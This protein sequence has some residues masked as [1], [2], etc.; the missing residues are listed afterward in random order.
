MGLSKD[1]PSITEFLNVDLDIHAPFDLQPLA[2]SLGKKVMV[3][4]VYLR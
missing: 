2:S 4:Y 1:H 3:L